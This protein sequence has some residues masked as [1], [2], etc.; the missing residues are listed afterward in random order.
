MFGPL[1]ALHK[2][3]LVLASVTVCLGIGLWL[4]ALYLIKT[5]L[6]GLVQKPEE[7]KGWE[8]ELEKLKKRAGTA[9]SW[10]W[11]SRK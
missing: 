8:L 9:A 6:P 10:L 1:P 3:V 5:K 2:L 11:N 4:G 7:K